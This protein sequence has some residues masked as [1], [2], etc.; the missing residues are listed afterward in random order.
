MIQL[1]I[2]TTDCNQFEF[3]MISNAKI[4]GLLMPD[5]I[6]LTNDVQYSITYLEPIGN[7]SIQELLDE[8]FFDS[9]RYHHLL[10][11][12]IKLKLRLETYLLNSK[13]LNFK[14]TEIWYDPVIN[15]Y[16]FIYLPFKSSNSLHELNFYRHIF[17]ESYPKIDNNLQLLLELKENFFDLDHFCTNFQKSNTQKKSKLSWIKNLFYRENA[18][19]IIESKTIQK[20]RKSCLLDVFDPTRYYEI[21]FSHVVIGRGDDCNIQIDD[22][23][24]S[25]KHAVIFKDRMAFTLEDLNSSNGTYHNGQPLRGTV[26]L[27]NGD[28]LQFGDK[29]FIFIL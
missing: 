1:L 2:N 12:I 24:I 11:K 16:S 29:E 23:S 13:N 17:I 14:V 18:H 15:N 6:E 25:R 26:A 22:H 27:V 21:H 20:S 10:S 19:T 9:D 4:E 8:D 7:K 5:S 28:K 3:D